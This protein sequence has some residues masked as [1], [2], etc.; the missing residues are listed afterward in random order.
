MIE[1][2]GSKD[3]LNTKRMLYNRPDLLNKIL[4]INVQSITSYLELQI[5]AGAQAVMIFDTW[6]GML[7][8]KDYPTY[9]LLPMQRIIQALKSNSKFASIPVIL[10]T[11][12]GSHWLP[13]MADSGADVI[14]LD[15]TIDLKTARQTLDQTGK[16]LAIQGNIDPL[17]LLANPHEIERRVTECIF[18]LSK[19][20]SSFGSPM[21]GHIFNLGHGINQLTPPEHVHSL[22]TAVRE[23]SI[24]ARNP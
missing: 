7:S 4:D 10:F 11:K 2:S 21:N 9:S 22:I 6:G 1:G 14:G 24:K 13:S 5:E 17:L 3:F 16:K 18:D 23:A 15:W 12:G 19:A 20:K 8:S